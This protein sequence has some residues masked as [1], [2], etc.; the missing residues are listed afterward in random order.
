M[1]LIELAKEKGLEPKRTAAI[2]GGEYH[3]ACPSCGGTDR[4]AI[5]PNKKREKCI[6]SYYC[7]QCNI[8]GD[9]I[10]FCRVFLGLTWKEACAKLDVAPGEFQSFNNGIVKKPEKTPEVA[11]LPCALW[12]E[13]ASAFVAWC[14]DRLLKTPHA[15]DMLYARGFT[16]D[17]I[18]K[19]KLGYNP[20]RKKRNLEEWGLSPDN[21]ADDKLRLHQG[22]IIPWLDDAEKV[23]KIK[24]RRDAY[25]SEKIKYDADIA[26]GLKP[27][28]K[29]SKYLY[30]KG[31]MKCPAIYG[32]QSLKIGIIM[33]SEYDAL[34]CQQ[35]AGDFCFSIAKCGVSQPI[36]LYTDHLM[37]R[38]S[39]ILLCPDDDPSGT[40]DSM[41]DLLDIYKNMNH[42]PAPIGKSPG[43][44]LKDHGINLREWILQGIPQ[45]LKKQ[46]KPSYEFTCSDCGGHS[47]WKSI[48]GDTY[49]ASCV[50]PTYDVTLVASVYR[51]N[52]D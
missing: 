3:C 35:F 1:D 43:D 40:G 8:K 6:G 32:D 23:L 44:A 36:D 9:T 17:S 27:E 31:G 16:D 30:I 48:F 41:L 7:R 20:E 18:R 50:S 2:D 26:K 13:K 49:C 45:A 4:F 25:E 22:L 42:W 15:M 24:V 29:P 46:P 19:F 10:E 38:A 37:R 47:Y 51:V 12:Q 52:L 34:L 28:Y 11:K 33:E 5:W 21:T 39:L 14:H